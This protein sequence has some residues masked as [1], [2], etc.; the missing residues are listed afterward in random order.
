M[1]LIISQ[2]RIDPAKMADAQPVMQAMI[3]A[4]RAEAGCIF[5]HYSVDMLDPSVIHVR[6]AWQDD[7]S[8]ALH[9]ASDHLRHWREQWPRLGIYGRD[10]Q[11]YDGAI[12]RDC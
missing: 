7:A 4:S 10:L 3:N 6:E 5:Y 8:F 1:I 11:R 12:V 2:F 9:V